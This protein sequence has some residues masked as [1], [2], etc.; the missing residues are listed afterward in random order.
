[1]SLN[2]LLIIL[3]VFL[4]IGFLGSGNQK[5][6]EKKAAEII[7]QPVPFLADEP[8]TEQAKQLWDAVKLKNSAG[9][10]QYRDYRD[11]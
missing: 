4:L 8:A 7:N 9:F 5:E 2:R 1:M 3:G 6:E 10:P 11:S